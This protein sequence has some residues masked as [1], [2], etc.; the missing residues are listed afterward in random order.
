[1]AGDVQDWH[2]GL[3][4]GI[5]VAR[6]PS[7]GGKIRA[8]ERLGTPGRIWNAGSRCGATPSELPRTRRLGSSWEDARQLHSSITGVAAR[9]LHQIKPL[10]ALASGA[11]PVP[12]KLRVPLVR[13][14]LHKG[15][16]G[17]GTEVCLPRLIVSFVLG[18]LRLSH[19]LALRSPLAYPTEH[20]VA[21]LVCVLRRP[22]DLSGFVSLG[23]D[24]V[25]T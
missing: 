22:V 14:R 25:T 2:R 15:R 21:N 11:R 7:A 13:P 4:Q 10:L 6:S 9:P 18:A 16:L 17:N 8:I 19:A 3:M 1:M 23:L 24:P 20:A 12:L 5:V